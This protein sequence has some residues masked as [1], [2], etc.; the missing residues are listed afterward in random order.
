MT[1]SRTVWAIGVACM[2]CCWV[3]TTMAMPGCRGKVTLQVVDDAGAVVAGARVATH[4]S[5]RDAL[6]EKFTGDDGEATFSG[7][8]LFGDMSYAVSKEGYYPTSGYYSFETVPGAH[9]RLGRWLPWNATNTVVLKRRMNPIEGAGRA[10]SW[11]N[12]GGVCPKAG[13]WFGFDLVVGDWLAPLGQ[14]TIPDVSFCFEP[15][16]ERTKT[17]PTAHGPVEL[18]ETPCQLRVV[19]AGEGN[20][21]VRR[22]KDVWSHFWF[23]Y[24]AP[25]AGY[26]HELCF[27]AGEHEDFRSIGPDF[28]ERDYLIVRIRTQFD[29]KGNVEHA[30]YGILSGPIRSNW[31]DKGTLGE[32]KYWLNPSDTDPNLEQDNLMRFPM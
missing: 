7:N 21:Y 24:L 20:G 3:A 31:S 8:P 16:E 18:R 30:R 5:P 2:L 29:E 22:K 28:G 15:G 19:F 13:E 17:V 12:V 23:D 32:M 4:F 6:G 11:R 1:T 9:Q 26:E 10:A 27:R 14:G 25:Q